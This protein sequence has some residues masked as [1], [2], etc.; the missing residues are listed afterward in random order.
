MLKIFDNNGETLDRFTILDT[1][2][3]DL[4]GASEDPFHGFGQHCGNVCY[5]HFRDPAW[6]RTDEKTLKQRIKTAVNVFIEEFPDEQIKL[7]Q[8]PEAVKQ[9]A[10]MVK[11][12]E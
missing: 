12:Y 4:Y 9:Y 11:S 10:M 8:L 6:N 7:S 1:T 2:T 3:G 5:N